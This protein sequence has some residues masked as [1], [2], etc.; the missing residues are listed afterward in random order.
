MKLRQFLPVLFT[1]CVAALLVVT[2]LSNPR[3]AALSQSQNGYVIKPTPRE[4]LVYVE[5][6][7]SNHI[8]LERGQYFH[9]FDRQALE[10]A[11]TELAEQYQIEGTQFHTRVVDGEA[12]PGL[13]VFVSKAAGAEA[14][15]QLATETL[16]N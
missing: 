8:N 12:V 2:G 9:Q 11:L 1:V 10:A 3:L 6:R 16:A 5:P 14:D 15:F 7:F 13:F 4:D